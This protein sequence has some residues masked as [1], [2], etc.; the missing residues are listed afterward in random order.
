MDKS[1]ALRRILDRCGCSIWLADE[2]AGSAWKAVVQPLM[3]KNKM[4][5]EES[6]VEAGMVNRMA[7]LY[8]GPPEPDLSA[9]PRGTLLSTCG[10]LVTVA[11]SETFYYADKPL[12]IWAVLN[13]YAKEAQQAQTQTAPAAAP[14]PE[15]QSG[16][17]PQQ[18]QEGQEA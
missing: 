1:R 5:V 18:E 4:Y 3:Y 8:L 12:Y 17:D 11:H 13:F 9:L 7:Y 16:Q 15:A 2:P 6:A 10:H 14:V